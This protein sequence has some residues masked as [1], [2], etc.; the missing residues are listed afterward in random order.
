MTDRTGCP[1]CAALRK[2]I[3][4]LETERAMAWYDYTVAEGT[5]RFQSC[6]ADPRLFIRGLRAIDPMYSSDG[7]PEHEI[8]EGRAVELLAERER[9]AVDRATA[10][11]RRRVAELEA[12]VQH[13]A[14]L[15][16]RTHNGIPDCAVYSAHDAA[17]V[18]KSA[19]RALEDRH[20]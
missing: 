15:S 20:D 16:L 11:L 10:A 8:S 9:R 13:M 19:R 17:V 3:K 5:K 7:D 14:E 12:V 1:E 2:Q 6:D 18:V 4:A